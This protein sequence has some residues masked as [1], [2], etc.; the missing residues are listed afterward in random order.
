MSTL[1][2]G[3]GEEESR[4]SA[5]VEVSALV[6]HRHQQVLSPQYKGLSLWSQSFMKVVPA[7]TSQG[8]QETGTGC[9]GGLRRWRGR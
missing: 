6:T 9:R 5:G 1:Q 8:R 7:I 2:S 3:G 4:T